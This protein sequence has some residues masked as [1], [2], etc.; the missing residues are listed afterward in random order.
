MSQFQRISTEQA[1]TL[2]QQTDCRL[3]DIRDPASFAQGHAPGAFP[4]N[5]ES[6]GRFLAEVSFDT[7]V[8]V[9]CYH[10]HSSQGAAQYLAGQGYEQVYSVDGGFADWGL[11]F[12]V[13]RS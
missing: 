7:P 5:Q 11:R 9:M 2:L 1:H 13:E 3:V 4:L 10:G 8:L 12:E 6:L